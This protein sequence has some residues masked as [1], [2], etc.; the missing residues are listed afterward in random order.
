MSL[1]GVRTIG[2]A[3]IVVL[4]TSEIK[5]QITTTTGRKYVIRKFMTPN[6]GPN[7]LKSVENI[8]G[9]GYLDFMTALLHD[10]SGNF[11]PER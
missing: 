5:D 3:E 1:E 2:A 6:R 11:V 7:A 4:V 8:L 10:L 9:S